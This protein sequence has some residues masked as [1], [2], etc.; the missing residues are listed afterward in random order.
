[1]KRESEGEGEGQYL[2]HFHLSGSTSHTNKKLY[3]NKVFHNKYLSMA[4][5]GTGPST[6]RKYLLLAGGEGHFFPQRIIMNTQLESIRND[7]LRMLE[8]T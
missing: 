3:K 7:Q 8:V 1:M 6:G 4:H 5:L 2:R